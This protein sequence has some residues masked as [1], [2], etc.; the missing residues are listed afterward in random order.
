MDRRKLVTAL[1]NWLNEPDRP[2]AKFKVS[3]DYKYILSVW[4]EGV[5]FDS[6]EFK[7]ANE[8]DKELEKIQMYQELK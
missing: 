8:M 5:K 4:P 3:D 1:F 6:A 7:E 2:R